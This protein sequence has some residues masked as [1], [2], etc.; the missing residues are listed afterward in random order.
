MFSPTPPNN[1]PTPPQTVCPLDPKPYCA[2]TPMASTCNQ[3]RPCLHLTAVVSRSQE[4]Y[5]WILLMYVI[6]SM[7]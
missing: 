2:P 3:H 4:M 6:L 7:V 5:I 1:I